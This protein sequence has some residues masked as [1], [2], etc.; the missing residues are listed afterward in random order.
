MNNAEHN[1]SVE[2]DKARVVNRLKEIDQITLELTR[3][4][5]NAIR[6]DKEEYTYEI[7]ILKAERKGIILG[8]GGGESDE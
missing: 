6:E 4:R 8:C 1:K 7:A 2:R 5:R 3:D